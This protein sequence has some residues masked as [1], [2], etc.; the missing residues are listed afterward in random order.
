MP[1]LSELRLAAEARAAAAEANAEEKRA[2][3]QRA[4]KAHAAEEALA[5]SPPPVTGA[6]Q[7][8][9]AEEFAADLAGGASARGG[10]LNVPPIRLC[11]FA[12]ST[13]ASAALLIAAP[14]LFLRE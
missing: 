12:K 7:F 14:V 9:S 2:E 6:V 10:G 13:A 8:M 4:A 3:A 1:S 11:S 5:S